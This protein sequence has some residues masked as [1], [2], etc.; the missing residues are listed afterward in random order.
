MEG[1]HREKRLIDTTTDT[2]H[3]HVDNIVHESCHAGY[4]GKEA[5]L[6]PH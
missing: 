1:E 5:A 3:A 4:R 6:S 2:N